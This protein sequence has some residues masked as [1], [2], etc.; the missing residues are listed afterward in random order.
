VNRPARG[1]RRDVGKD[2]GKAARR[3]LGAGKAGSRQRMPVETM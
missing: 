1:R 2:T 3:F